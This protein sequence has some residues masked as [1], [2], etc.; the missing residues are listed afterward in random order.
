MTQDTVHTIITVGVIA[1]LFSWVPLVNVVCPPGWRSAERLAER[2]ERKARRQRQALEEASRATITDRPVGLS[3]LSSL[4]SRGLAD[5][6][7]DLFRALSARDHGEMISSASAAMR[8]PVGNQ[9][10]ITR[11]EIVK[12]CAE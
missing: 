10:T 11:K 6:S 3:S 4:S 1:A 9:S 7:R 8:I 2:K 12:T 5:R